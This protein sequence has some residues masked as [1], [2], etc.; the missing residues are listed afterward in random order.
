MPLGRRNQYSSNLN[1]R[2]VELGIDELKLA[3]ILNLREEYGNYSAHKASKQMELNLG[4]AR[5]PEEKRKDAKTPRWAI[6]EN[7]AEK[8]LRTAVKFLIEVRQKQAQEF[9]NQKDVKNE[10]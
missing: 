8:M 4:Y 10:K 5:T 2:A 3:E 1:E 7:E 9:L 6:S